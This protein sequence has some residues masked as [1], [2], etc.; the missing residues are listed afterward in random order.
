MHRRRHRP[1]FHPARSVVPSTTTQPM[2]P[3]RPSFASLVSLVSFVSVMSLLAGLPRV[4]RAQSNPVDARQLQLQKQRET[5]LRR[6]LEPRP[7]D[8]KPEPPAADAGPQRLPADESPC[9]PIRR[10]R[11]EGRGAAGFQW[12]LASADGPE[13][14]DPPVGRCLG[15]LGISVVRRRMLNALVAR[16]FV[17]SRV[18]TGSQDLAAGGELVLTFLPGLLR[19]IR[20]VPES[21]AGR[22]SVAASIPATP[23]Q[24]LQ[25]RDL[26]QGLENLQRIPT[27]EADIVM[28]GVDG[29]DPGAGLSDL[30]VTYRPGPPLRLNLSLDDGGNRATGRRQGAATLSWDNPLGLDDMLYA[31]AGRGLERQAAH[32]TGSATVNYALPLGYWLFG[33]TASRNRYHQS[34]AGASQDYVYRG[35]SSNAELRVQRTVWRSAAARGSLG[36]KTFRRASSNYIDDTEI[37]VQHL[38]TSG[39][40]LGVAHHQYLG[41]AV[42][43]ASLAWRRGTG[44]YGALAAPEEPFGEGSS[45]MRLAVADATLVHP[46]RLAGQPLRLSSTWHAQWNRTPLTPQDRIAIGSRYTVRGFDGETFLMGERGW[47]LR[48]ELGGA[49]APG[50]EAYLGLDAGRVG[51]PSTAML[52][53]RGL[54]G[55]VVG[56]RGAWGAL[57]YD[58]F[59]GRP[60]HKPQMLQTARVTVGFSASLGF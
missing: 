49:V 40:E 26:E 17:T 24:P 60:L 59:V 47:F 29:D 3:A 50:Q 31:S 16:G 57:G 53:G 41:E 1:P 51:G 4:S 58:L 5:A 9:H 10:L 46:L 21:R 37:A 35:A 36:L 11:L 25:L 6:T 54:V 15:A 22:R 7:Q 27:A 34:V 20:L 44:A 28:V 30:A 8:L 39:W 52:A 56:M 45:R 43:D 13:A 32:G 18:E 42:L 2:G 19:E 55:G 48:T 14:D 33:A 12:L 23:G 38:V